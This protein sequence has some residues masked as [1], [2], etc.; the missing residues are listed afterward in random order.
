MNFD[1]DETQYALRDLARE[2]FARESPPARVRGFSDGK[3][4]DRNAWKTMAEAGLVGITV[5]EEFGGAGGNEIDLTLVY[6]EAGRSAL[7][8]PLLETT[9]IVA[10]LIAEHGDESLRQRLLPAIASG[11]VIAA[12]HDGDWAAE[13]DLLVRFDRGQVHVVESG[14]DVLVASDAAMQR[15]FGQAFFGSAA[16]LNGVAMHLLDTTVAYVKEREQFGRPVGSFQAIKHKLASMHTTIESSRAATWYAGYAL[17]TGVTDA[18]IASAIAKIAANDSEA[19]CNGEALQCHG[20]IGF[21]WEHDLHLWLKRGI[22]LRSQFGTS[23][24]LRRNLAEFH[25]LEELV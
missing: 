25:E 9:G 4:L 1:F 3:P 22:G 24:E 17:A 23:V 16:L 18:S 11:E 12:V 10:P 14:R 15:A 5:P 21:T 2:L 20:G 7:P 6:E 13:A 8:D 19:L